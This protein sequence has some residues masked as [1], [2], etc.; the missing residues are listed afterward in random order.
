MTVDFPDSP[1]S[2]YDELRIFGSNI[3][4]A[5]HSINRTLLAITQHLDSLQYTPLEIRV[6]LSFCQTRYQMKV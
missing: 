6:Y 2:I 3:A 5:K 1:A 4:V